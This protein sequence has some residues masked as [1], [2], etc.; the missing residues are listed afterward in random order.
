MSTSARADIFARLRDVCGGAS[1]AAIER[2]R[3][4]LGSAPQPNLGGAALAETFLCNVLRNRGSADCAPDRT[5]AVKAVA[6]YLYEHLRSQ[7]LVAGNDARLAAMPWRDAGVLPR[8]GSIDSA[9]PAAM[10]FADLAIAEFGAVV[11]L[12]GRGNPARNSLLP[13][14]HI[15][16]VD[17]SDLV[18][19]AEE[20]W[21]RIAGIMDRRARPRGIQF[22]AGPSSTADIE[23]QLVYGAHGPRNW[24]VILQGDIAAGT[25][26]R[27]RKRAGLAD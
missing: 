11:S 17:A 9:E 7:R 18:A 4:A 19:T 14:H 13:E 21:S 20:A 22:I 1:A 12:T 15:V 2:E 23:G 5:A 27:A 6:A 3:A 10:S 26:E 24:H 16:L 25:L 8:F